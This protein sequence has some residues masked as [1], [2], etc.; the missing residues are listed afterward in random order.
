MIYLKFYFQELDLFFH[1][2]DIP[3]VDDDPDLLAVTR[4]ALLRLFSRE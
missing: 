1:E 4:L 3:V 2:R